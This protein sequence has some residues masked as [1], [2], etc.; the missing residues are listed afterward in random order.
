MISRS[1]RRE[2]LS[3]S[4]IVIMMKIEILL[5]LGMDVQSFHFS[6]ISFSS[7]SSSPSLSF[8]RSSFVL[9]MWRERDGIGWVGETE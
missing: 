1:E 5:V 3:S 4:W 9:H 7:I 6:F 2:L 8:S